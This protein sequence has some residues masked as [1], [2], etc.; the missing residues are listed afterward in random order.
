MSSNYPSSE[1]CSRMMREE[2]LPAVV[3]RHVCTVNIVAMT[4]AQ[5]CGADL[6][7]V[8]AASLLHDI[9]RSRTHGVQHVTEGVRIAREHDL[10]E[11]LVLCISRHIA[12]GFTSE[13]AKELGL[14]DGDYMPVTLEDKVVSFADNLVSDRSIKTTAQTVERMR[15]KGFELSAARMLVI[16]KELSELCGEDIDLLLEK[17]KVREIAHGRCDGFI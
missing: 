3:V 4:I 1:D 15:S 16:G 14:P 5:R 17:D 9:G 8:N 7:L 11:P 12:S 10:P 2:M 6:E 13:E